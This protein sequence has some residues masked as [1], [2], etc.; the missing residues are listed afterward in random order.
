M[1]ANYINISNW[2][3]LNLYRRNKMEAGCIQSILN[4]LDHPNIELFQKLITLETDSEI[5]AQELIIQYS[6]NF[7][8]IYHVKILDEEEKLF[9]CG[10]RKIDI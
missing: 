1:N 2:D 3:K 8:E 9:I 4:A 7:E 10:K 6:D 5:L